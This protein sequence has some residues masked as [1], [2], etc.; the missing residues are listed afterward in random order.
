MDKELYRKVITDPWIIY[1]EPDIQTEEVCYLACR[2]FGL[3]VEDVK[4]EFLSERVQV[5]AVKSFPQALWKI[6]EKKR[7]KEAC[8]TAVS[9][10]WRV[11]KAIP[12][13]IKTTYMC[14]IAVRKHGMYLEFVPE[15]LKNWY[16]CYDAVKEN[17]MALKFVPRH[18]LETPNS[19]LID[20]A[21]EDYLG[22]DAYIPEEL[23]DEFLAV[24]YINLGGGFWHVPKRLWTEDL[25]FLA[26]Q[27]QSTI[28]NWEEID[29]E[30]K[31]RLFE[32]LYQEDMENEGY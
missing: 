10:D 19:T 20:I 26:L 14:Q 12:D 11:F 7:C 23:W 16:V 3:L 28:L 4:E 5:A 13:D 15:R 22:A 29:P 6:P 2:D 24:K 25:I 9:L 30:M 1:R 8:L 17:G 21:L 32:R 18:I 27:R 31:E